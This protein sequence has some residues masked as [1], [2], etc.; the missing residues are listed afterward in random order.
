[1]ARCAG[2]TAGEDTLMYIEPI[3][4]MLESDFPQP[5]ALWNYSA[6]N[7]FADNWLWATPIDVW[8]LRYSQF[9]Q[10]VPGNGPFGLQTCTV[11]GGPPQLGEPMNATMT[12]PGQD[13]AK[14]LIGHSD[15][16]VD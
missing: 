4:A 7:Q 6:D 10:A 2:G 11:A 15:R 14:L 8:G 12:T 16:F 1:M 9:K 3:K 13:P 5:N